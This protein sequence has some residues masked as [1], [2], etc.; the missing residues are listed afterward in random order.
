MWSESK[1]KGRKKE[2]IALGFVWRR[3][4][5]ERKSHCQVFEL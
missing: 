1:N 4:K 3:A 2:D 5:S